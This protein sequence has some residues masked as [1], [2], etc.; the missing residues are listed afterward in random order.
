ME[1]GESRPE[2]WD[3]EGDG[4]GR[5]PSMTR[6]EGKLYGDEVEDEVES[7]VDISISFQE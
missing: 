4:Q 3:N 5:R 1:R 2:E 6:G 7:K